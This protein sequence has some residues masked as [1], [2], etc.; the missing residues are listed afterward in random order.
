MSA[1][2]LAKI[3]AEQAACVVTEKVTQLSTLKF[4]LTV[5]TVILGVV[6]ALLW[7]RSATVAIPHHHAKQDG[8]YHDGS[9]SVAGLDFLQTAT[10][11]ARWN[12]W[13]ACTAAL[14]ALFQAVVAAIPQTD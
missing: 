2:A 7:W 12:K 14:A 13:A 4:V 8:I 11:Q 10:A 3:R 6:S 5:V 1:R 9:I